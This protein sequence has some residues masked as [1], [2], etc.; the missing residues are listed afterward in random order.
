MSSWKPSCIKNNEK[1][2]NIPNKMEF[3]WNK[4]KRKIV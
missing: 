1:F 3:S 4:G 2:K